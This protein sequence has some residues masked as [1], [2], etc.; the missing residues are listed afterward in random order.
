[1][2]CE[3]EDIIQWNIFRATVP[4]CGEFTG[5]RWIPS[6]RPVTRSFDCF[7]DL[8]RNKRLSKQPR[9]WWFETL[10]RSLWRHCNE[11]VVRVVSGECHNTSLMRCDIAWGNG[12]VPMT[13]KPSWLNVLNMKVILNLVIESV[14]QIDYKRYHLR[15]S[16]SWM[17]YHL[18]P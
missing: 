4:F 3:H 11:S 18:V 17:N 14:R 1:M 7:F 10:S 16:L 15:H 8:R 6:Q 5:H 13:T 2:A 12:L 9:S